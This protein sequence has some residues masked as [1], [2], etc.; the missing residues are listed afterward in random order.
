MQKILLT[1]FEKFHTATSNP[2]QAIVEELEGSNIPGLVTAVLPVEFS[3]SW[4]ILKELIDVSKPKIVIALGQAEGRSQITPEKIAIN[5]DNARIPDNAGNSPINQ[6]IVSGG[7]DGLSSTL[8][9]D[10]YVEKLKQ[11]DIPASISYSAGTY[12]CNHL[13]YALQ[14]YCKD[15]EI[16]SGFIHVPLM[17]SQSNEFP[18]LPTLPLKTMVQAIKEILLFHK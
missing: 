18:G 11:A 13:F 14:N 6:P 7:A 12:V 10:S 3:R 5:L 16:R 9:I 17:E 1:G 8:P 15:K 4:Q 2:T